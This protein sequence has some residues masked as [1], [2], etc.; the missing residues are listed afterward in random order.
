[1]AKPSAIFNTGGRNPAVIPLAIPKT[2]G[3][4]AIATVIAL[5]QGQT[6]QAM[7]ANTSAI[8][9]VTVLAMVFMLGSGRIEKLLGESGLNIV[10]RIFGLLLLAIAITS[11]MS[12]LLTYFPGLGA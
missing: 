7:L 4:G 2:A 6:S 12:S 11:I 1:M 3:P 9:V 5:N 8:A 10:S